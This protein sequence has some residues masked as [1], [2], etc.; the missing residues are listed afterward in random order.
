[1]KK[2]KHEKTESHMY[3]FSISYICEIHISF[4]AIKIIV[5]V[6]LTTSKL[7][8]VIFSPNK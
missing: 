5:V 3:G 7:I 1:M 6:I 2:K 4:N 8:C